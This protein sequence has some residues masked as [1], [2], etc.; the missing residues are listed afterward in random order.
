MTQQRKTVKIEPGSRVQLRVAAQTLM[1]AVEKAV[2][3]RELHVHLAEAVSGHV[4]VRFLDEEGD[5][6]RTTATATPQNGLVVLRLDEDWQIDVMRASQRITGERHSLRGEVQAGSLPPGT[7]LDFV[8]LDLS[9]SGC[10]TSGVGRQPKSGD[11][12]RLAL[13][14]PWDE[15]RWVLARAMRVAPLAFGRFEVGFRFEADEPGERAWLTAWRD[16]WSYVALANADGESTAD[17]AA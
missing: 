16:A 11:L 5:A 17:Q 6:W 12:V 7:R 8:C 9:A 1:A 14:H 15:E 4:V 10:R 2:N 3:R 13:Q